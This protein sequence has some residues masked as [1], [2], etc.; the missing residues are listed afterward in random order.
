MLSGRQTRT[1][2]H[3]ARP[4]GPASPRRSVCAGGDGLFIVP[5]TAFPNRRRSPCGVPSN[6]TNAASPPENLPRP[7]PPGAVVPAE[8]RR[9]R[10]PNRPQHPD[11]DQH[12]R[13]AGRARC[14][15]RSRPPQDGDT[16]VFAPSLNGQTITLTSDELAIKKSLDIEG[17]GAGLLA[18]SGNDA[19]RVFDISQK[20]AVTVTIAG[21]TI[22]PRPGCRGNGRGRRHL[23]NVEQHAEPRQRRPVQ[24]RGRRHSGNGKRWRGRQ[25]SERRDP[26]GHR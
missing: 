20:E 4:P 13:Q 21:L 24:Q 23:M 5:Q 12:P 15:T 3:R 25:Q 19:S 9:P 8:A 1:C 26:H 6:T 16:I 14:G 18:I 17:P 11:G 7:G 2:S 22:D 10:R